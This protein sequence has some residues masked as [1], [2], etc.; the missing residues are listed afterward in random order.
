M[1]NLLKK[2]EEIRPDYIITTEKDA[3]KL[4]PFSELKD[5]VWI[6]EIEV[7]PEESWKKFFDSFLDTL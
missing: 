2:H 3:V 4:R 1:Q 7:S 5:S 6:L